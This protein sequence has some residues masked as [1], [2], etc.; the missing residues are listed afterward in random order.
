MEQL[1][2]YVRAYAPRV[3]LRHRAYKLAAAPFSSRTR[4]W[5]PPKPKT[6]L[7]SAP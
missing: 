5:M 3:S 1:G 7:S 4:T 6:R 2:C